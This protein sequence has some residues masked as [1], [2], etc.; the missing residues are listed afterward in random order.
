[1]RVVFIKVVVY[2]ICKNEEKNVD[3]WYESMKEADDIY[4]LDTGSTDNTIK[5]FKKYKKV[6][7]SE[8]KYDEFRFDVAR[9]DSLDLVPKDVDICVCTDIDER[10]RP[11]WREKIEK[12]WVSE[13]N[14]NRL[15]YTYNWSLTEDGRPG[16][17]FWLGKIH[18]RENF[19][20]ERPI[21]EYL[22]CSVVQKE[23]EA[24]GVVLDHFHDVKKNRDFY[25]DLLE[26]QVKELP[27][28]P[29]AHYLLGREYLV[30]G[31]YDD[32]IAILHKLLNLPNEKWDQER[33]FAMRYIAD[34]YRGKGYVQEA[35]LFYN[36]AINETPTVREPRFYLGRYYY[37]LKDYT[38]A[39]R[40]LNQALFIDKRNDKYTNEAA[41]WDG[42][43]Y[44]YLADCEYEC[45]Y[46]D[47][48]LERLDEAIKLFPKDKDLKKKKREWKK[49]K[50]ELDNK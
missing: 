24:P 38:N 48:A 29:R 2:A 44:K 17:T 9:N 36:M 37:H 7:V 47:K 15:K 27:N 35:I 26:V 14:V 45:G 5:L 28:D 10:F 21:H 31:R 40:L 32:C 22:R 46:I 11:G 30:K 16:T 4:V 49:K 3:L 6:H 41:P 13:P 8:K 19:H 39:R 20:W 12:A 34:S 23:I 42:T 33:A 43:I 18:S 25:L 1:M 50:K